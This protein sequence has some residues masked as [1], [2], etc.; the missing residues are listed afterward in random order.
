MI[1]EL[2]H[3]FDHHHNQHYHHHKYQPC[4]AGLQSLKALPLSVAGFGSPATAGICPDDND[5][6][7]DD[8]DDDND[9][10]VHDDYDDHDNDNQ[11]NNMIIAAHFEP[12]I[13]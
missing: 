10:D 6:H 1:N 5:D 2:L 12:R 11:D 8:S 3:H 4:K 9:D 7:D 13:I